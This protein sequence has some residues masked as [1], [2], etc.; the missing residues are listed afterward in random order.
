MG[1]ITFSK[2]YSSSDD[3]SK[4][5]GAD[6]Q[7]LQ[8]DIAEIL[9]G[10][11][12]NTNIVAG[13]AVDESKISFNTST[14]HTHNGTDA[15]YPLIKHY[16]R[17][18]Q[19]QY[20]SATTVT[21]L[22]GV[23]DVGGKLF[24]TTASTTLNITTDFL[25]GQ[26]EPADGPVY[27]YAYNN[28]GAIGFKMSTSTPALSDSSSNTAEFPLRY[29]SDA[30]IGKCRLIGIIHNRTDISADM[31]VNFD[32]SNFACGSF[33][34]DGNDEVIYTGWTPNVIQKVV[35]VDATPANGETFTFNSLVQKY[36][37]A[38]ANPQPQALLYD[39]INNTHDTSANGTANS[40]Y[41]INA[42]TTAQPGSFTI[43]AATTGVVTMW[44]AFS[45]GMGS[46]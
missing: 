19:I 34:G 30:T 33:V 9:N 45:H 42:Q 25:G 43:D 7:R 6:L 44:Y 39:L 5:S 28:S 46:L 17:G 35:C 37:F 26:A 36:G 21:V 4:L 18:M 15:A 23:L 8:T 29:Y 31:C 2:S 22:P 12:S 41:A 3:G 11:I 10:G 13:G 24:V 40:I 20:A 1:Y 14:G 32:L 38:T 27:I 16:R